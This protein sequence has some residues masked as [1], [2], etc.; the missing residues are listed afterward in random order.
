MLMWD[1]AQLQERAIPS[2]QTETAT[3]KRAAEVLRRRLP[4]WPAPFWTERWAVL[5]QV[6]EAVGAQQLRSQAASALGQTS[7]AAAARL[8]WALRS[9]A[10][11]R[12]KPWEVP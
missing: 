8:V 10:F 5:Q 11:P 6:L 2:A 9:A 12:R 4:Q 7:E 3:W 1:E